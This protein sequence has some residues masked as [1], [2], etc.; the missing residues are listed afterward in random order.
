MGGGENDYICNTWQLR[1]ASRQFAHEK[2]LINNILDR[3]Y[4]DN[5]YNL[6]N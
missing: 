2:K 6:C 1:K 5:F 3:S 4:Q